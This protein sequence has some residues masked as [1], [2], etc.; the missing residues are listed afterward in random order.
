ML[1]DHNEYLESTTTYPTNKQNA[2]D[3]NYPTN[4]SENMVT[5]TFSPEYQKEIRYLEVED[6]PS[7]KFEY[8][9][10]FE[11]NVDDTAY[12]GSDSFYNYDT[13]SMKTDQT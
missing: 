10:G 7:S 2:V 13:L 9:K 4:S 5:T 12:D 3:L 11:D 8:P 1:L 6:Q